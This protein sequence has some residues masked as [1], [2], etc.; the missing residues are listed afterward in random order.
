MPVPRSRTRFSTEGNISLHTSHHFN[1]NTGS[2]S[3][4]DV[5]YKF[6]IIIIT[7]VS[8]L[9]N[10]VKVKQ[11]S[12]SNIF[13]C[14]TPP[15]HLP[16]KH[17]WNAYKSCPAVHTQG[18]ASEIES[19]GTHTPAPPLHCSIKST[20]AHLPSHQLMKKPHAGHLNTSNHPVSKKRTEI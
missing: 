11:W 14:S 12:S 10:T 15:V 1:F 4:V 17:D 2:A 7:F 13:W 3:W 8:N 6:N 19:Q 9:N 20:T 18:S 5:S 16:Y